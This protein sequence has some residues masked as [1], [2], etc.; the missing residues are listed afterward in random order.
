MHLLYNPLDINT[1]TQNKIKR[2]HA[3]AHRYMFMYLCV[4]MWYLYV[5]ACILLECLY[6]YV[7][8]WLCFY[9]YMLVSVF[10]CVCEHGCAFAYMRVRVCVLAV[11][12]WSIKAIG[13][14]RKLIKSEWMRLNLMIGLW[15]WATFT[16]SM[17]L[18]CS[19]QREGV[20]CR[21]TSIVG[22]L[23]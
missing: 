12:A 23:R 11:Y 20:L 2:K 8:M 14:F 16:N 1:Y 18:A 22:I 10:V 3:Y 15:D 4:C 9:A 17:L 13:Q 7:C 21:Y 19:L 5:S 6:A